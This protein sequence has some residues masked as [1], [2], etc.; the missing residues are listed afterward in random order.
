M[1]YEKVSIV[2]PVY[3]GEKFIESCLEQLTN[4]TYKNLEIIVVNDGSSDSSKIIIQNIMKLDNRIFYYEKTNGGTGSALNLG[5]SKAS[6]YYQTW[7]SCDDIKYENYIEEL[8]NCLK[9]NPKCHFVFSDHEEKYL[10]NPKVIIRR[11][12]AGIRESGIMKDFL[13]ITY[14]YCITGIC[15]MFTKK[16]KDS[17]GEFDKLAGE[18]YIMGAKMGLCSKVY[19]LDKSLGIHVLHDN[20][21][22]LRQPGCTN[23]ADMIVRM[24]LERFIK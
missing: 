6:G 9:E 4:Q 11:R 7:S 3:N 13:N 14:N 18:D 20:C 23:Q 15:F 19:Y 2:V 24:L 8:V 16:I 5:F 21:L 1:D 10:N 22:T 12:L 17:I